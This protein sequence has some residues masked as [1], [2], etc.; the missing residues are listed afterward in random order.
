MCKPASTNPDPC[1]KK[2]KKKKRMETCCKK[3]EGTPS[4]DLYYDLG[5]ADPCKMKT[6]GSWDKCCKKKKN[7]DTPNCANV[8]PHDPCAKWTSSNQLKRKKK[9]C[10]NHEDAASCN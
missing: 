8:V 4:C 7:R 6:G 2:A 9:C 10:E 5:V 3:N 1:K